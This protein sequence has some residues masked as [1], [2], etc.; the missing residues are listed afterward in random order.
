MSPSYL[1]YWFIGNAS[2]F[3]SLVIIWSLKFASFSYNLSSNNS[4]W[5]LLQCKNL[6]ED[7]S[8][9]R[10][11]LCY[12][13]LPFMYACIKNE[14]YID[15]ILVL[16]NQSFIRGMLLAQH[17]LLTRSSLP[18]WEMHGYGAVAIGTQHENL[19]ITDSGPTCRR[20]IQR[21]VWQDDLFHSS[22]PVSILSFSNVID[23][24]IDY[25]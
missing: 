9:S 4:I 18:A 8:I 21:R 13:C 20:D 1:H 7:T 11:P 6:H 2:L 22:K 25:A 15:I 3:H 24:E 19:W 10:H 17:H 23:N 16:D 12:C 14:W 5:H